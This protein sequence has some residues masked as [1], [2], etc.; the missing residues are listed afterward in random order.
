MELI[1]EPQ[2]QMQADE[3]CEGEESPSPGSE[4]VQSIEL[5]ERPRKVLPI[6][7]PQILKIEKY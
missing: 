7:E 3:T 5:P 2:A 1:V 4:H 6:Y